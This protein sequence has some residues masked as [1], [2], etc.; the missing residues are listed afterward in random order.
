M[1]DVARLAHVSHQ[2]VSRVLNDHPHVRPETRE[3]VQLAIA[4][5]GYRR[6]A[7]A[8]SLVTRR[9]GVIGL[10]TPR[11]HLYGPTSS[12]VAV[13]VAARDAGYFVSLASVEDSSAAALRAA[14]EHFKDQATEAV[15]LIAPEREWLAAATIVATE[16]PVVTLCADYRAARGSMV[17]VAMDNRAGARLVMRHLLDLGHRSIAFIAGPSR[18]PEAAA[19][20]RS[21]RDE[22][23]GAGLAAG[24][25]YQGD[26]GSAS[27]YAAG[28]RIIADGLPTAVFAANDQMALGLLAALT[29]AGIDVPGEVSVAGFDDLPDAAYFRPSLTTVH[30][31][32]AAMA[33]EC[34]DV[35][36][37]ILRREPAKSVRI[38]PELIVRE[39]TD[40]PRAKARTRAR[41]AQPGIH[42]G[43]ASSKASKR[44]GGAT[45][46]PT[47]A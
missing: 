34:V 39:S 14:V 47:R 42:P 7:A 16:M 46:Q 36:E 3:R 10:L 12:M 29:E 38:R 30:Q 6:N 18:S 33:A 13:E 19:R 21:W 5:L 22:L 44:N 28:R 17:S 11:T 31:D 43:G 1:H 24:R 23:A 27:G 32:F 37:H 8:R 35:L 4:E 15:V 9:S 40:R 41:R 26:W 25:W 2:T 20:L 45:V